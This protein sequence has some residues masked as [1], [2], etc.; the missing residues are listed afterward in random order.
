M[1]AETR[2]ARPVIH[3]R[4]TLAWWADYLF[5]LAAG[6]LLLC[7]LLLLELPSLQSSAP[8]IWFL[9]VLRFPLGLA[10]VL[11][12][13]GYLLQTLFFPCPDDLDRT[14]RLGFSLG[15]SLALLALLAP[16]LD[17][18]PWGLH[19][20]AILTGQAGLILLLLAAGA[21]QR[22]RLPAGQADLP[23]LH[24]GL[25]GWWA[26][27]SHRERRLLLTLAGALLLAAL[28]AFWIFLFPSPDVYLTEFYLL[29]Q[30]GLAEAYPS[31]AVVGQPLQ[32]TLGV[33]N[34]ERT[35][36][37][38][39]VEVWVQDLQNPARRQQVAVLAPFTLE[40]V[41]LRQAPLAWSMV[42]PGQDQQVDFLLFLDAYPEPY[43]H[44]RLI[45][46]V[47]PAQ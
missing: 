7:L 6:A 5:I 8:A 28:A 14:E 47:D 18:L 22:L 43:R 34:R 15:F 13:P 9:Q 20:L 39:R 26:G 3:S 1:T 31:R 30:D 40:P 25:T 45:L 41:R 46:N 37:T 21:W 32:I 10:F 19:P 2:L 11:F 12:V 35:A 23:G 24:Q 33:V 42:W 38:Y 36:Q 29:G 27:L 17:S 44:L 16:L 4:L